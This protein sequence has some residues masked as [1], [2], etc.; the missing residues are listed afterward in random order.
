VWGDV[1]LGESTINVLYGGRSAD[2]E[3]VWLIVADSIT[4]ADLGAVTVNLP[5]RW[6]AEDPGG[7][8]AIET[9]LVGGAE[10]LVLKNLVAVVPGDTDGDND[11]DDGDYG[12][13]IA[14]F[15]GPPAATDPAD[16]NVDDAVD[17]EDFAIL[18]EYFG[19]VSSSAPAGD[20]ERAAI[21]EPTTM[22][23]L[24]AAGTPILLKKYAAM[25][26]CRCTA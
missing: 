7:A 19:T 16:F 13:L 10:V 11:V 23:L 3:D 21:P 2:G 15:G 26:R 12:H 6:T 5:H 4:P 25:N 9:G 14:Q 18:R 20:S 8:L 24:W 17:I 1:N 22:L